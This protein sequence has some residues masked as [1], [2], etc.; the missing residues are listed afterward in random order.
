VECGELAGSG[1]KVY[2]GEIAN[3]FKVSGSMFNLKLETKM[4]L[5]YEQLS[6]HSKVWIYQAD[7]SLLESEVAAINE[8]I[9]AFLEQWTAHNKDLKTFG[10]IYY[11]QF[12]VLMIDESHTTASGCSIDSSVN[13]LKE[14]EQQ[15][16]LSLFDRL[17]IAYKL[18]DKIKTV[19]QDE[20]IKLF[21]DGVIDKNTIVFNNLVATKKELELNWE[22]PL[23]HSWHWKSLVTSISS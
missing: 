21:N 5:P 11:H 7:R 20:F 16:K 4:L 8:K 15:Y 1:K 10:K 6:A 13:F 14:I 22:V 2:G 9:A 3:A 18:N 19:S 17:N 23:K 12:L